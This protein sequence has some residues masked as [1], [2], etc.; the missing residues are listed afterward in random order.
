MRL[1]QK[2]S[3]EKQ[4]VLFLSSKKAAAD[5]AFSAKLKIFGEEISVLLQKAQEQ[6][7]DLEQALLKQENGQELQ[8]TVM[9]PLWACLR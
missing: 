1:D 3:E 6:A 4:N 5:L 7:A 9:K 2:D 8:E